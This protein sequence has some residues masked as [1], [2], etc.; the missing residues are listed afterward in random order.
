MSGSDCVGSAC[1]CPEL[2]IYFKKS[3]NCNASIFTAE[4]VA[5]ND[6]LDI[7]LSYE[8]CS[9]LVFTDSLSALQSLQYTDLNIK[10]NSYVFEIKKSI[11]KL[12]KGNQTF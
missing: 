7:A 5:L 3:I 10:I 2:N 6:A 12:L 9:F 1:I 8:N 11:Y 4:C